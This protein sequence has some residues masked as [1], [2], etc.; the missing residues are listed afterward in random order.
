VSRHGTS[1]YVGR[2][3]VRGERRNGGATVRLGIRT[4]S[5]L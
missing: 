4:P 2:L 5:L 1:I 3:H